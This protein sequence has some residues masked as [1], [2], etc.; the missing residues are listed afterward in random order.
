MGQP[1]NRVGTV[2][3]GLV[4]A[5]AAASLAGP[6]ALAAQAICSAP[7]S[8]PSLA[9]GGSIGTLPAGAGWVQLSLQGQRSTEGFNPSGARQPFLGG[10]RFDTRSAY[11]TAAYGIAPGL[12]VWA[13]LPVH[14]LTATGAAGR[15]EGSGLGDT[16]V[17]LRVSPDLVGWSAPF[18]VRFGAKLPG[19]DLPVDARVLPLTEGQRDLEVS[20]E[21]GWSPDALRAYVVAWV[22][23]RWRSENESERFRPGDERFAHA[24]VG[25]S[26]G[27]V[28]LQLGIDALWGLSPHDQ[29]LVLDG[30]R[31]RLVQLVPT[32]GADV[33]PGRLEV[34]TPIPLSGQ[35]LPAGVGVGIGYRALWGL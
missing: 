18:A 12:E 14:R 19:T 17:A 1:V 24:A 28:S 4:A 6:R 26:V 9:Q 29:G 10:S 15:S 32:L 13:Q 22:G 21:S 5:V 34:T 8:S 7:H 20:V 11:V 16:R 30:A 3:L 23:Y 35:N 25:G 31:R 27:L 33:G 2:A